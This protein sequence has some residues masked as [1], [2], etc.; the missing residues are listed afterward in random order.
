MYTTNIEVLAVFGR[1]GKGDEYETIDVICT[2]TVQENTKS[3]FTSQGIVMSSE[4]RTF[5]R[6]LLEK[7]RIEG[8]TLDQHE[9]LSIDERGCDSHL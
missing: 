1:F 5:V 7:I 4:A 6:Q 2:L 8:Y 3:M 9:L